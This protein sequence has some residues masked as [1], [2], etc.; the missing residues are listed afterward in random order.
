MTMKAKYAAPDPKRIFSW[1]EDENGELKDPR[2]AQWE[3]EL[4]RL[5]RKAATK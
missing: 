5:E 3:A 1:Q 2:A 4:N